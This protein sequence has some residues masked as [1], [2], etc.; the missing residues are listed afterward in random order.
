MTNMAVAIKLW[1][2][3]LMTSSSDLFANLQPIEAPKI[4]K[5]KFILS[6]GNL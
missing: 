4:S 6:S 2:V 3:F 1:A 5:Q